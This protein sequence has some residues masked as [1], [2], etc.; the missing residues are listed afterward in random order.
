MKACNL[1][2]AFNNFPTFIDYPLIF[3]S[4]LN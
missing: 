3:S 4:L 1:S 2:T